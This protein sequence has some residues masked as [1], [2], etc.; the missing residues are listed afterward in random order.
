LVH[1][2]MLGSALAAAGLLLAPRAGGTTDDRRIVVTSGDVEWLRSAW[3]S[4]WQRPPT[5]RELEGLIDDFVRE[6]ILF[7][8][9]KELDL[10]DSDPMV[11]GRLVEQIELMAAGSATSE[12]SEAELRE[13]F[14]ADRT[15][16]SVPAT[17]SFT[18]VFFSPELRGEAVWRDAE[19]CLRELAAMSPPPARAP[20]LGDRFPMQYDYPRRSRSEVARHL[21]EAFADLLFALES[22]GWE[23]PLRSEYGVHLVRVGERSEA[24]E[25]PFEEVRELVRDDLIRSRRERAGEEYYTQL[26][27]RF[28]VVRG[29]ES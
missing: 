10:D 18:H 29:E 11:R 12:P 8:T 25:R 7:R 19:E 17:R 28:E 14:E 2:L 23:G 1:F 26:R 21:G 5:D 22:D 15:R 24:V 6:E 20:E 13:H 9:A 27:S 3:E 4:R 16:W